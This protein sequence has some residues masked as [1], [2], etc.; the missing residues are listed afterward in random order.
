MTD[1][2]SIEDSAAYGQQLLRGDRVLLRPLHEDDLATLTGWWADPELALLQQDV[3]QPRPD[4]PV[5]EMFRGWSSN[6]QPG[7]A[8]F[9]VAALDSGELLGHT[10]LYG[11]SARN[12]SATLAIIIGPEHTGRGYG[13]DAVEVLVRYGFDEMGLHRI[14]LRTRAYNSRALAAY[15]NVG[16]VEEGRRREAAFHAGTFHDDVLMSL[17]EQEWRSRG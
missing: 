2:R 5:E 6:S 1:W 11:A 13:S 7:S 17:L 14:E 8:G 10:A 4:A 9:S 12:R 3:V 15:S 16:F